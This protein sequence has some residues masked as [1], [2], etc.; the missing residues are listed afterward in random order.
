L[1]RFVEQDL[2]AGGYRALYSSSQAD[3]A[4]PQ[5]WHRKSGFQECGIIEGINEGGIGEIFFRK[6]L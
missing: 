1:L 4:A 3:E 5:A 2:R 6:D